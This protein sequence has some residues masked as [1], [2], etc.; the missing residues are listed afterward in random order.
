MSFR[1]ISRLFLGLLCTA[2]LGLAGSAS[3]QVNSNTATVALTA[4]LGETLTVSATPGTVNFTLISGAAATGSAPIVIS[5]NWVLRSNRSA[6]NMYAWFATPA[7]A[8][9]D[10]LATPNNIPSSE[11]Y[12]Q[13]TTGTPTSYTAF[14]QSNA[15][16][17]ASGGL[18]LFSQAI[19]SA[20]RTGS[21]SDN[22]GLK[23]DLTSQP[24]LPAGSYSGTV[25]LQAQSL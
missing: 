21:R 4:T 23:I 25:T 2:S 16:G 11:V 9:T 12:G 8:L 17:T 6:V 5:T 1:C 22:L 13:V 7:A 10:G 3:A 18:A 20:N 14:A 19:T 24:Q 15:L